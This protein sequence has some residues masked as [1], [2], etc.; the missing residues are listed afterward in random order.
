MDFT[1]PEEWHTIRD[2]VR[3]FVEAE[4]HPRIAAYEAS[5]EFPY[6]IIRKMGEAGLFGAAFPKSMG[7]TEAGLFPVVVISEEISRLAPEFGYALNQQA[8]TCPFTILNWGTADQAAR[9]VPDLIAGQRI[10]MFGLSEPSGGSDPAGAIRTTARRDGDVYLV[11]GSKQWITFA[12]ACDS[13]LLFARTD[14]TGGHRG[15]SAFVIEPKGSPRYTAQPI[16]MTGLSN[17][18]RSCAVFFDD[19]PVPAANRLGAEGDGFKIAMNA[20]EYGRLTV[21]ARL[22]GL[23]QAAFEHA[24]E[25]ARTRIIR[26]RPLAEYQMVQQQVADMAVN[27]EAARLLTWKTA[28]TMERG[29]RSNRAAAYAKYFAGNAARHAAQAA[30]EIF[31]GYALADDYPIKKITAYINMLCVG[32]G[33]PNVQRVL[34]AEDALG[35]KDADRHRVPTRTTA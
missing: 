25:Y 33:T 12:N 17:C 19:F 10:G 31:A 27:I 5:R 13:G 22:V 6:P 2:S 11:N 34:I 3:R 1:Q 14:S 28:W 4:I 29:M 9:F 23:A 26:G 21:A 16:A 24:A 7:G 15:I 18:L 35:L 32:E 20:L 8:M 30:A